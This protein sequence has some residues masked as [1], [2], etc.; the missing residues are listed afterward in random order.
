L[1]EANFAYR[2]KKPGIAWLPVRHINEIVEGRMHVE[3][4]LRQVPDFG[5]NAVEIYHGFITPENRTRVKR[6]LE[7]LGI[8]VSQLTCAPD[9]TNP[10]PAERE[11]QLEEM[12]EKVEIAAEL[13]AS[14]VRV[15]AGMVHKDLDEPDGVRYAVEGMTR[16]LEYSEP[17]SIKLCYE[18]H[19]KDRRW[20]HEDFSFRPEVFLKIFEAIEPTVVMVNFD[21]AN[22]LMTDT[23]SAALLRRVVHK[24]FHVHAGDRVPG[25]YQ[26]CVLGTGGVDFDALLSILKQHG[27]AGY[28]TI[29]D[30][31]GEGDEGFRRSVAFLRERVEKVYG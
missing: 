14:A 4:W 26:H 11:R 22:P 24:V 19:Y 5:L 23:D 13:G 25:V 12:K 29:E 18:N 6:L 27:Y 16:L 2:M 7:E 10:D 3:A 28:L 1:G 20:T 30:G 8:S 15:T 21:F 31:Q 17:L 9:F